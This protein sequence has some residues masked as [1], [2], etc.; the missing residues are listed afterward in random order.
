MWFWL[1]LLCLNIC[2]VLLCYGGVQDSQIPDSNSCNCAPLFNMWLYCSWYR[3]LLGTLF[4]CNLMFYTWVYFGAFTLLHVFDFLFFFLIK[5]SFLI[6]L[7]LLF[8]SNYLLVIVIYLLKT[9][10]TVIAVS[11]VSDRVA[12]MIS[13][14]E[15]GRES[16]GNGREPHLELHSDSKVCS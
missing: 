4:Y 6:E 15:A 7:L 8:F 13:I 11:F 14:T 3:P 9:C 12:P 1:Y 5:E 10:I 2:F 16:A